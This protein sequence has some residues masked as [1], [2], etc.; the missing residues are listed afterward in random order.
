MFHLGAGYN[1]DVRPL[2]PSIALSASRISRSMNEFREI[3]ETVFSPFRS[4]DFPGPGIDYLARIT[5]ANPKPPGRFR[6]LEGPS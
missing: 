2:S 6:S 4:M 5:P 3:R 1:T